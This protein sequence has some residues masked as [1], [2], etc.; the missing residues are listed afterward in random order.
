M[1]VN[2]DLGISVS[3]R[4]GQIVSCWLERWPGGETW[5]YSVR[6]PGKRVFSLYHHELSKWTL[7]P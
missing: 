5:A 7:P 3:G 1:L 6:F 4:I 2:D